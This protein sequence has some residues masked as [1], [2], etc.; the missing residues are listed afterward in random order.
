MSVFEFLRRRGG[1]SV[2]V[3]SPAAR[4]RDLSHWCVAGCLV[5]FAVGCLVGSRRQPHKIELPPPYPG[6]AD[7][8]TKALLSELAELGLKASEPQVVEFDLSFLDEAGLDK[9]ERA[10]RRAG[11][12]VTD[13]M[14]PVQECW[15]YRMWRSLVP[16]SPELRES[17]Q[18]AQNLA[19]RFG[20]VY[21][22]AQ[23]GGNMR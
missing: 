15:S 8:Q 19:K 20:G 11:Y 17:V 6:D 7:S 5:L 18:Y 3:C 14:S 4:L 9:A 16:S 22:G 23:V 13:Y 2:Y 21:T 1:R 10:G 12:T